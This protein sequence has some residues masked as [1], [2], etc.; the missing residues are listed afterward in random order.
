MKF[1]QSRRAV[2][3]LAVF[4]VLTVGGF[5]VWGYVAAGGVNIQ[6][7]SPADIVI[8]E[9]FDL[10]VSFTN[11]S[12][13]PLNSSNLGLELP[14]GLVALQ[15]ADNKKI[16]NKDIGI[17]AANGFRQE[18]FKVMVVPTGNPKLVVTATLSYMPGTISAR[19]KKSESYELI[20]SPLKADLNLVV[21][22]TVFSGEQFAITGDYKGDNAENSPKLFLKVIYPSQFSKTSEQIT[23]ISDTSGKFDAKG[24]MSLPDNSTFAVKVQVMVTLLGQDYVIAEKEASVMVTP[25]P[26]SLRISLNGSDSYIASAGDV[27]N[28][29]MVYKNNTDVPLQN[30]QLSIKLTG[31]MFDFTSLN[32]TGGSFNS[33]NRT[34]TWTAVSLPNLQIINPG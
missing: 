34:V 13:N 31:S 33:L 6:I 20:V 28:Y 26:L 29:S 17:I 23:Q 19:F 22:A 5:Y 12:G 11:D 30:I 24:K 7:T 9:P 8:G 3:T 27:L 2:I 15:E 10:K 14:E 32:S 1:L 18:I 16:L 4:T 25:S 21:P